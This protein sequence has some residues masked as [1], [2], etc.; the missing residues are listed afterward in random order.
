MTATVVNIQNYRPI[1]PEDEYDGIIT[2]EKLRI[3]TV[4]VMKDCFENNPFTMLEDY[5]YFCFDRNIQANRY[6][7]YEWACARLGITEK[8][9]IVI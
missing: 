8:K 2:T 6:A 1:L 4:R 3:L 5:Q 7:H 9:T